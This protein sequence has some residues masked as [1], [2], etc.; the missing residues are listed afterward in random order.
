MCVCVCVCVCVRVRACTFPRLL[1]NCFLVAGSPV[2]TAH[3]S[4]VDHQLGCL[5][6]GPLS[7]CRKKVRALGMWTN[8]FQGDT[9]GTWFHR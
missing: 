7:G 9:L 5:E 8:I 3:A 6:T 4:A 2:G 1:N